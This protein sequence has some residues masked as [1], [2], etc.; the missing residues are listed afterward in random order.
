MRDWGGLRAAAAAAPFDY[1]FSITN[2][3]IVPQDLVALPRKAAINF[4]DG[5][6]PAWAGLNTPVW[7][8]L[9]GERRWAITWHLMTRGVDAGDV[10]HE[11]A[12]D[13]G[14][15]DSA[16]TLQTVG[17]LSTLVADIAARGTRPARPERRA[18]NE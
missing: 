16:L 18:A 17:S 3:S 7:G 14:E 9:N 11:E 15:A 10:L 1:L 6:L 8:L 2:L 12:F 5:P 4:H 13:I